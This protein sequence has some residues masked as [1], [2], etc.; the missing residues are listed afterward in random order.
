MVQKEQTQVHK[1]R[2]SA[3]DFLLQS[4]K[5]RLLDYIHKQTTVFGGTGLEYQTAMLRQH[6]I[7]EFITARE[8]MAQLIEEEEDM[9]TK[10]NVEEEEQECCSDKEIRDTF[11]PRDYFQMYLQAGK[12]KPEEKGLL[13]PVFDDLSA[14]EDRFTSE[15]AVLRNF[16]RINQE[17]IDE[18]DTLIVQQVFMKL[19]DQLAKLLF[20]ARKKQTVAGEELNVQQVSE[21]T[22]FDTFINENITLQQCINV[23]NFLQRVCGLSTVAGKVLGDIVDQIQ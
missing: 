23:G 21:V 17:V 2:K 19:K 11:F 4:L 15:Y 9:F 5:E 18:T 10:H 14:F 8:D 12:R 22:H 3:V 7:K 20:Q 16:I 6:T 13:L 1:L